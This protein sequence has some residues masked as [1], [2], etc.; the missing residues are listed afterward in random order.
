MQAVP[1]RLGQSGFPSLQRRG[2]CAINKMTRSHRSGA[3]GV[4]AH[5]PCFKTHFATG[6]VSDHPGRA[7]SERELFFM[8]AATPPLEGG[9]SALPHEYVT[10]TATSILHASLEHKLEGELDHTVVAR[11]GARNLPCDAALV[12]I[13]DSKQSGVHGC[14]RIA[15][16]HVVRKVEC[17]RTQLNRA[18]FPYRERTRQ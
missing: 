16:V 13:A 15:R 10:V 7:F 11:G 2:G 6:R 5:M 4:V 9:E 1:Y 8:G 18:L 12:G 3:D 14:V 17:F